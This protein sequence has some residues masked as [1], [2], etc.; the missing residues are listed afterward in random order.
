MHPPIL[1][2]V[3][4]TVVAADLTI[5]RMRVRDAIAS[6]VSQDGLSHASVPR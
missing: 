2:A 3:V 1:G 4:K 5:P 6:L